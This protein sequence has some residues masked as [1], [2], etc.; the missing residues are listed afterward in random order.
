MTAE[1]GWQVLGAS[2]AGAGHVRSGQCCQDAHQW[3]SLPGDGIVLAVADGAGSAPHAE[4][5][6]A[7]VVQVVV[8]MA[9]TRLA[10]PGFAPDA[11]SDLAQQLFQEARQAVEREAAARS[12]PLS[13]LATTLLVAVMTPTAVAAAQIGDG[14]IVAR[15][16]ED[17]W[18][19]I[20]R[21]P[22]TEYCNETTFLT[23][24]PSVT[25]LQVAVHPGPVTGLAAFSDGLQLL[26]LKM[27][28]AEPH[29][30]FF[31]PLLRFATLVGDRTRG[32]AQLRGF[33]QSPR[34]AQRTDDDLTLVLA[35]RRSPR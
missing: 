33:L 17:R 11:W 35:A 28:Q 15:V 34:V 29:V 31:A 30:P 22:V 27:P 18:L 7:C 14:A 20:T 3:R 8:E 26:A 19:A 9:A 25:G 24:G 2:V 1:E 10:Q 16:A 13:D 32:E 23:S 6:S 12:L 5:G 4:V 21:P